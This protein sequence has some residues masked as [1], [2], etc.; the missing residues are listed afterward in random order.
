VGQIQF[1]ISRPSIFWLLVIVKQFM[2]PTP[3]CLLHLCCLYVPTAY[4]FLLLLRAISYELLFSPSALRV[5]R[6]RPAL[7]AMPHP[8]H[9]ERFFR[10]SI[11]DIRTTIYGHFMS[12][13]LFRT[14]SPC[15]TCSA[16]RCQEALQPESVSPGIF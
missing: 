15:T 12:W 4:Y 13:Y 2:V 9:A 8:P 16:L 7:C 10:I 1:V 6:M 11:Y 14:S 5:S 3:H